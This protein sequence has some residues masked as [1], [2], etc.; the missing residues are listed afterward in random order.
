M[1]TPN[2][3]QPKESFFAIHTVRAKLLLSF[4]SFLLLTCFMILTVFWFDLKEERVERVFTILNQLNLKVKEIS[5]MEKDFFSYESINPA[6]YQTKESRFLNQRDILIRDVDDLLTELR[7]TEEINPMDIAHKIDLI[8]LEIHEFEVHFDTLVHLIHRRG[9]KDFGLEGK[10]RSH[11]HFIE[12]QQINNPIIQNKILTIRRLEKDFIIRKQSTYVQK[13]DQHI[14]DLEAYLLANLSDSEMRTLLLEHLQNYQRNFHE[15]VAIEGFVGFHNHG[16]LKSEL[17]VLTDDIERLIKE[18]NTS[19][20]HRAEELS[21]QIKIILIIVMLLGITLNIMLGYVVTQRLGRPIIQLSASIRELI[22]SDFAPDRKIANINTRDEIGSLSRD[23]RTMMAKIEANTEQIKAQNA[24]ISQAYENVKLL[25]KIGQKITSYLDA[26][27]I[28]LNVYDHLQN[29][30]NAEAFA[31][32]I[33]DEQTQHL[34]FETF[35]QNGNQMPGISM[36][37]EEENRLAIWCLKNQR[38]VFI[39]NFDK[40]YLNYIREDIGSIHGGSKTKSMVYLPLVSKKKTIGVLTIQSFE[41]NAYTEY[42]LNILRNLATFIATALEN[43]NAYQ[44]IDNQRNIISKKNKDITDSINYAY[45]IQQVMLPPLPEI[46]KYLPESFIFYK[47]RDIVSGDFYWFSP[48]FR[49]QSQYVLVAADC[50]GH[51]VP[52]A[53]MSVIGKH[54][55]ENII[56]IERINSPEQVLNRLDTEIQKTLRHHETGSSDGMDIAICKIDKLH[57]KI[58]Y[59][60]AKN[61]LVYVQNHNQV[62]EIQVIKAD[63]KSIGGRTRTPRNISYTKHLVELLPDENPMFY[64][65]SDGYKDQFGGEIHKKFMSKRLFSLFEQIHQETPAHQENAVRQAL[66]DWMRAESPYHATYEKN[67]QIDDILLIGFRI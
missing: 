4:T 39:N 66:D 21:V 17:I 42:H 55:L 35:M 14:R 41:Q 50:T 43:A 34:D 60:G 13:L 52:G 22:V 26:K 33:Y 3:K 37:L 65:Y 54:L 15:L 30:M 49:S 28:I 62:P 2:H 18:L 67:E 16:G 45:R 11:I 40:E 29:L 48:L 44:E 32:G 12:N 23:L 9:F 1:T 47:P 20:F 58:E 7:H 24:L 57:R 56:H 10:M 31:V 61:P 64:I 59:A 6:F 19:V 25:S 8:S 27:M 51:G 53:F 5:K 36:G 63:R 38:E 46:Q